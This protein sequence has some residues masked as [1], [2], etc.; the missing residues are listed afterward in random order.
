M[1]APHQDTAGYLAQAC[2]ELAQLAKRQRFDSLAYLLDMAAL[3]AGQVGVAQ[4]AGTGRGLM[5]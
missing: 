5:P 3:E 1:A 2:V 4:G